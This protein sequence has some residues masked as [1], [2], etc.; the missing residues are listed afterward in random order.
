M[1][2]RKSLLIITI[3]LLAVFAQSASFSFLVYDDPINITKNIF[4]TS[5]S[6]PGLR[7]L[8]TKPYQ[9]LYIPVTYTS[10][11]GI[12]SIS[13][14]LYGRLH[15]A[16]FHFLNVL[17]HL[18]NTF[19]VYALL[20]NLLNQ[21]RK[22]NGEKTNVAALLAALVF[23][24]HPVQVEPVCWATGFKD[25]LSAFFLLTATYTVLVF[26]CSNNQK[27]IHPLATLSIV[28]GLYLMALLAK[29]QAVIFPFFIFILVKFILRIKLSRHLVAFILLW[30]CMG[31][32]IALLTKNAQPNPF[33]VS[34]LQRIH[35]AIDAVLFYIGKIVY[36]YPLLIDYGRTL[37]REISQPLRWYYPAA[38][39][40]LAGVLYL[41]KNGKILLACTALALVSV[42][43]VSGL[44][45]FNFQRIS[46]VADRYLYLAIFAFSIALAI[47]I[48][49]Y[50]HPVT[51]ATAILLVC[52]YGLLSFQ[53]VTKWHDS[54]TLMRYTLEINPAS[55]VANQNLGVAL[56]RK[57]KMRASIPYLQKAVMLVPDDTTTHFNLALS[58]ACI[59]R[60]AAAEYEKKI[61]DSD[62][63]KLGK[64]LSRALPLIKDTCLHNN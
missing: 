5:P 48:K 35:I 52:G 59:G 32:I 13:N 19:L 58:Y 56:M 27:K 17:F 31:L 47:M 8:W 39:V 57:G 54:V 45:P 64:K 40:L 60:Q 51:I 41:T 36:P 9:H 2:I 33:H 3:V 24:L 11:M 43:P 23:G 50:F 16:L 38:A 7:V 6:L 25:L 37:A 12:A 63:P 20:T 49:K 14:I 15:P 1:T 26:N 34:P 10:W 53:Y 61:V 28:T 42:A 29:P 18:A 22:N 62:N 4:I 21:N 30:T 44:M 46:I 55:K